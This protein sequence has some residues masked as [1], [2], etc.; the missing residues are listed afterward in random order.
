[1]DRV[2]QFVK[3]NELG[4]ALVRLWVLAGQR[5]EDD[6]AINAWERARD[7]SAFDNQVA[8]FSRRLQADEIVSKDEIAGA[9]L[10]FVRALDDVYAL[11]HTARPWIATSFREGEAEFWLVPVELARRELVPFARQ[12]GNREAWFR[13]H[14]VI[15]CK[16]TQGVQVAATAA[17]G[18]LAEA[19]KALDDGN[20]VA[21]SVWIGHFQDDARLKWD[22]SAAGKFRL[23]AVEPAATR[24]ASLLD[25]L[26]RAKAAGAFAVMLPEFTIDLAARRLAAD[27]LTGDPERPFALVVAGSFHE[28][29]AAGWFN[30]AELWNCHA[31]PILIHRKLRLFGEAE[32]LAEDVQIGNEVS[33]LVTPIGIFT[34]LICKDFLDQHQSVATLL[35]EIPVDWVLVPSYGD[36][37]TVTSHKKRALQLA[38]VGPGTTS[39]VANQRNVEVREG[40]ACPGFAHSSTEAGAKDAEV[41]GSL[42]NIRVRRRPPDPPKIRRINLRRVK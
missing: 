26:D 12:T 7:N 15:P 2:T 28:E 24:Q 37:T 22:S 8:A 39:V 30:T 10:A 19:L 21:L 4:Q 25:S 33:L 40:P 32:G 36:E 9:T 35:Q 3:K 34:L 23:L 31:E 5:A 27:W 1:M 14:A 41:A 11:L 18:R 42:V 29:T 20:E 16:T 6:L 17:A 13:R 38:K